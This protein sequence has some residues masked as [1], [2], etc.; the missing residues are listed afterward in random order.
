MSVDWCE[1]FVIMIVIEDLNEGD[2]LWML[3][4]NVADVRN[5]EASNIARYNAIICEDYL[6]GSSMIWLHAMY[7]EQMTTLNHLE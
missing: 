4:I 1:S 7:P 2:F 3:R 6:M 5:E